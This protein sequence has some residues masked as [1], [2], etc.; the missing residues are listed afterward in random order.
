MAAYAASPISI[1]DVLAH[2]ACSR[3]SLFD[4]FRKHRGYTPGEFLAGERL[5]LAHGRLSDPVESDSV[6]SIAY[7]S[8]FSHMG[9]FSEVYRKRYGVLPSETL[10][11]ASH[12]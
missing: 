8:G 4:N 6:T 10:K 11:R 2:T 3:K 7:A 1:A 9:R 12:R 5:A